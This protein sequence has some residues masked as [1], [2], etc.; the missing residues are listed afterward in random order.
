M[1]PNDVSF[2]MN[3]WPLCLKS[4]RKNSPGLFWDILRSSS[5]AIWY[6]FTVSLG[7]F[8]P[9]ACFR[10]MSKFTIFLFLKWFLGALKNLCISFGHAT[11][12]DHPSRTKGGLKGCIELHNY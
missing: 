7:T 8:S 5:F 3:I 1:V 4:M 12:S 11:S 9:A 10:I 6:F 2:K